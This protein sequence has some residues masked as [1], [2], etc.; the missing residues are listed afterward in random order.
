M[1]K[2]IHDYNLEHSEPVGGTPASALLRISGLKLPARF[3]VLMS[4][5]L[6]LSASLLCACII[7]FAFSASSHEQIGVSAVFATQVL[8]R[9]LI[10]L[11]ILIL[12]FMYGGLFRRGAW[13]GRELQRIAQGTTLLALCDGA[14]IATGQGQYVSVWMLAVWPIAALS[15]PVFRM[16]LRTVPFG[17]PAESQNVL[18]VGGGIT[19]EKFRREFRESRCGPVRILQELPLKS[20]AGLGTD[21]IEYRL[22]IISERFGITPAQIRI[23]LAPAYAELDQAQEFFATLSARHRPFSMMLPFRGLAQRGLSLH[24]AFGSDIVLADFDSRP[25]GRIGSTFKRWF[26][27]LFASLVIVILAPLFAIIAAML[28][29]EGG[30]VFF[31]QLRVG[32]NGERFKCFK[33]RSMRPDAEEQLAILLATDPAARAEWRRHQKLANDPRIT[34]LGAFLRTTSLD[35]LPQL[36]NVV[37]GG[38]SIVGPRPIIAPEVSG[39][40]NDRAYCEGA[41]FSHYASCKPGITGLWQVSGRAKTAYRERIRLDSWYCRNWSIWLDVMIILKTVRVVL[42][43]TGS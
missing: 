10:L 13:E 11:P 34:R 37:T 8:E 12:I 36:F 39:Y 35:E 26:D 9:Y 14:L 25:I 42:I 40:E 22:K 19:P 41:N 32:Q 3:K 20:F 24:E 4:D 15:V 6:A 27:L 28:K 43:R 23:V 17:F 21:A 18:L 31:T 1:N 7:S 30:R 5:I 16:I 33:F 2:T 38:M 29:M